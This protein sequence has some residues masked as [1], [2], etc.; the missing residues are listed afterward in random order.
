ML[1]TWPYSAAQE[2]FRRPENGQRLCVL[3][4]PNSSVVSALGLILPFQHTHTG[5]LNHF[6]KKGVD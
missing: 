1:K 4:A 6:Q 5:D 3:I 2:Q